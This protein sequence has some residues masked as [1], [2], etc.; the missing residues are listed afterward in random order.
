VIVDGRRLVADLVRWGVQIRELYVAAGVDVEPTTIH[1]AD[2]C[3]ELEPSVFGGIAP[4]KNPQGV[5]AVADEPRLRPWSAHRGVAVY[6][7][8]VQEPG[9]L[10]AV[11]RCVA[12]MGGEAVLLS[13]G[14]ADPYHWATVRAS[15]GGV[16]RIPMDRDTELG[17]VARQM[18]DRGGEVW[19]AGTEGESVIGWRPAR[20]TL[21]MVGAEGAGL[22][23]DALDLAD[24]VV[25]IPLDREIDS[26]NVAVAAGILLQ[27]LRS[28]S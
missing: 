14:C 11:A 13:P 26:L 25:A 5:L 22:S 12:A 18:R 2:S 28:E 8:G 7:E 4:T 9:N 16:F 6:L 24:G 3:W 23:P 27:H 19:A 15:A 17:P 10:G 20:P 21:L 1:A